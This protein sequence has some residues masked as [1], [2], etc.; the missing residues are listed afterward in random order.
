MAAAQ[1]SLMRYSAERLKPKGRLIYSTCSVEPEENR[2]V[3]E[4]FLAERRDIHEEALPAIL[5]ESVHDG[6]HLDLMGP[7]IGAD[8]AFATLLVRRA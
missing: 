8:G 4:K 1:L 3:I 7:E 5:P 2:G 6:F